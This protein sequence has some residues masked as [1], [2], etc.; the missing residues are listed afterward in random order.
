MFHER[1]GVF[2]EAFGEDDFAFENFLVDG[3]GVFVVEGVDAGDHFVEEDA[4]G[5]PVDGLAVSLVQQDLRREVLRGSAEGVCPAFDD[6][7]EPEIGEFQVA[8]GADEQVLGLEVSVDDI[9][10]VQVLEHGR[11][12]RR[13][14]ARIR[15]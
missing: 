2:V 15:P 13:V 12:L 6:L 8:V 7:G 5:P 14:E 3:H 11:H 1:F 4:E 9:L 10:R